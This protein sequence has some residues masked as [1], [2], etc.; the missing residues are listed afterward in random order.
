MPL[1]DANLGEV[2]SNEVLTKR[3]VFPWKEGRRR[4]GAPNVS[5]EAMHEKAK[6][7]VLLYAFSQPLNDV[8]AYFGEKVAIFYAWLGYMTLA[9][10]MPATVS[11]LRYYRSIHPPPLHPLSFELNWIGLD[12]IGLDWIGL[13]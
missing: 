11:E 1:H 2:L 12:W 9:L 6:V 8:R 10:V 7:G 4:V 13:N 5:S 3:W